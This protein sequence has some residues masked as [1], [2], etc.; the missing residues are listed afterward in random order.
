MMGAALLLC[1]SLAACGF[2]LRGSGSLPPAL[3]RTQ[4]VGLSALDPIARELAAQLQARGARVVD[5]P[6]QAT[7][8]L[9]VARIEDD[10]ERVLSVGSDGR[11]REYEITQSVRF[12]VD[13]RGNDL[14]LPEETLSVSRDLRFDPEGVLAADREEQ[15]LREAMDRELA[16]MI[17]F[18]MQAMR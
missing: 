14:R 8:V 15:L 9:S 12:R 6:A 10:K 13:G 7:A 16:Q 3:E 11:V 5:D 2:Q 4:V 1:L 18:R 17:L